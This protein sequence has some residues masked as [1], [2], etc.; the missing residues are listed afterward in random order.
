MGKNCNEQLRGEE[1]EKTPRVGTLPS[2]RVLILMG[3]VL[4]YFLPTVWALN[5]GHK[6]QSAIFLTNLFFGWT[7]LGWVIA[8]LWAANDNVRTPSDPSL[9]PTQPRT[10][11]LFLGD[12]IRI[13]NQKFI[14]GEIDGDEYCNERKLLSGE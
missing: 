9:S 2:E 10:Q 12:H 11:D 13:L 6:N 4:G 3:L 7:L 14:N 1:K 8:L 5:R